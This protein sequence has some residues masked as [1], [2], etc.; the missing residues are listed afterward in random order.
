[1]SDE[2]KIRELEKQLSEQV[3]LSESLRREN[4]NPKVSSTF[5]IR[6]DQVNWLNKRAVD[7]HRWGNKSAVVRAIFDKAMAESGEF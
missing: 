5:N 7:N 1:M 6:T 4:E 2:E 3:A